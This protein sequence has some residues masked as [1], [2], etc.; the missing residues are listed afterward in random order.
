MNPD[1]AGDVFV[2]VTSR[3]ATDAADRRFLAAAAARVL[4]ADPP[5]ADPLAVRIDRSCPHCGGQDHGR[6]LVAAPPGSTLGLLHVSLSRSD[7]RLACALTFLGPV[8]V[9]IQSVA[10]VSRAGF[11]TVAFAPA[12]L[13][14]LAELP[15]ADVAGARARLWTAKE[16]VL[17]CTGD[18]LRVDPRDL[19]VSLAGQGAPRLDAWREARFP[20]AAM[21]LLGFNPGAGLVGTV[22]VLAEGRLSETAPTETRPEVRLVAAADIRHRPSPHAGPT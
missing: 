20:V 18:G 22:A 1:L 19:G 17:K 2:V 21:R 5:G 13:A 11:D 9:D 16:A 14:A 8:G 10:A 6:P 7:A 4:G 3:G 12:E 15:P